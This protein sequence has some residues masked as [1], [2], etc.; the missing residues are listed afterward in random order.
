MQRKAGSRRAQRWGQGQ[1]MKDVEV[2]VRSSALAQ[3]RGK[4]LM[5]LSRGATAMIW[6]T[7]FQ[8]PLWLLGGD[9]NNPG[10]RSWWQ[11]QGGG[12]GDGDRKWWNSVYIFTVEL[13]E[14]ADGLAMGCERNKGVE[15]RFFGSSS[16]KMGEATGKADLGKRSSLIWAYS[17]WDVCGSYKWRCVKSM[18]L[19]LLV[20]SSR[21]K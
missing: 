11:V 7:F 21:E 6:P 9:C 10:N 16:R 12:C 13:L 3:M 15:P 2:N 14:F 1:I 4:L 17:V 8:G 19:D 20:P 18:Q 5:S